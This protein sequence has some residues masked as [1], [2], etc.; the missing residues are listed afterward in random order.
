LALDSTGRNLEDTGFRRRSVQRHNLMNRQS[1]YAW[2]T[3]VSSLG[4]L[5]LAAPRVT[6]WREMQQPVAVAQEKLSPG[7]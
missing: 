3:L 2:H 6:A 5:V 7:S 1:C 4:L